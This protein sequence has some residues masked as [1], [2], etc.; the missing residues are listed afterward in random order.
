MFADAVI[1]LIAILTGAALQVGVGIG[2]SIVVAPLMMVLLGTAT[3]VPVL[4]GL[5]TLVS[6]VAVEPR[7][8][9]REKVD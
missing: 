2:F 7:I 9:L 6:A 8:W 5:N 1:L 4:L 3:A